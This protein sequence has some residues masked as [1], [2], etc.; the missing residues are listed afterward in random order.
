MFI[1][2][3]I[4]TFDMTRIKPTKLKKDLRLFIFAAVVMIGTFLFGANYET[5]K[6]SFSRP[7]SSV[8]ARELASEFNNKNFTFV[9]VHTPYEGEIKGTDLFVAY[10]EMVAS[11]S[12]L[13][14]DKA[15]PIVLYCKTGKMSTEAL[16]TLQDM[17][18]TNVRQ[19]SGGMEAWKKAGQEVLDLSKLPDTV[20]PED[21]VSLPVSWGDIGKQLVELGV[22]DLAKFEGVVPLTPEEREILTTRKNTPVRID[23]SNSRFVVNMLW[24]LGL[25]QKS[26]VYEEGP[27]GKEH[28][29]T[30]GNFASTGGWTLARG[31]ATLYLGKYD[32]LTLSEEEQKRVGEIVKNIYRPCCGNSTWFPD[33]NHGMAALAAVELMVKAGILD[34]EIYKNVLALNS[35]WFPDTYLAI[36]A[37]FAR[38]GT[39]WNNIDA[40]KILG[41]E[42][43][44][45]QGAAEITK[46][47]KQLPWSDN[48]GGSCG[49]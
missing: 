22:I 40:K 21:G 17:G 9:N 18:Y 14:Q 42:F 5:F 35:Y 19:L 34:E 33:C 28:K 31:N 39:N 45:A 27:M 25:A 8:S 4:I 44:S 47:V 24:A 6:N 41:Q 13:P 23:K 43:S 48:K 12:L 46:K 37:H 49:A 10:D 3:L 15:A 29:A 32:L 36:A 11:K 16:E 38:E 7:A 20:L 2:L 30:A 1:Y 26:V